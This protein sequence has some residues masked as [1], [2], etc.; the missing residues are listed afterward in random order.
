MVRSVPETWCLKRLSRCPQPA[1][2]IKLN[3][4]VNLDPAV[5]AK[6]LKT[7]PC[8]VLSHNETNE[9]RTSRLVLKS[10]NSLATTDMNQTTTKTPHKSRF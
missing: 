5:L 6:E 2:L 7:Q 4:N 8:L 3:V 10:V 1:G 9:Y